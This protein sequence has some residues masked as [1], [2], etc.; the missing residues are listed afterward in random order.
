[1]V[2]MLLR[3]QAEKNA[4]WSKNCLGK[5]TSVCLW[6]LWLLMAIRKQTS[7]AQRDLFYFILFIFT[8][9][10]SASLHTTT[11]SESM[12]SVARV[13]LFSSRSVFLKAFWYHLHRL[14]MPNF[15]ARQAYNAIALKWGAQFSNC[16][17]VP[18][19]SCCAAWLQQRKKETKK[20]LQKRFTLPPPYLLSI[21][22][23]FYSTVSACQFC[24]FA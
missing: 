12:F 4:R 8:Q 23:H 24:S 7:N 14:I 20:V 5:P 10:P 2:N 21:S 13:Q 6:A 9:M 19:N 15:L 18:R 11:A 3:R 1:M 16:C 17:T 22:V